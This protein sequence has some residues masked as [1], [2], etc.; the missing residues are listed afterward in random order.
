M[1]RRH[2]CRANKCAGV[3]IAE[4]L[5]GPGIVPTVPVKRH[6]GEPGHGTHTGHTGAHG[7]TDHTDEPHNHPNPTTHPTRTSHDHATAET[8]ADSLG[9][10]KNSR[11]P[12]A[13]R[14][15]RPTQKRPPPANPTLTRPCLHPLP[16]RL[17]APALGAC[18]KA[19]SKAVGEMKARGRS[20]QMRNGR[21][22]GQ[23]GT[24]LTCTAQPGTGTGKK[25][26]G[27]GL[28]LEAPVR[29]AAD[30]SAGRGRRGTTL[31]SLPCRGLAPPPGTRPP[32]KAA[33]TAAGAAAGAR[34]P[35]PDRPTSRL[36]RLRKSPHDPPSA[37]PRR[38]RRR[39]VRGCVC[40]RSVRARRPIRIPLR[41]VER[42]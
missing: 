6:R 42:T 20:R 1:K 24:A 17:P 4:Y 39:P 10:L 8:A 29:A 2:P 5:W 23:T 15:P 38:S 3:H 32:G 40:V 30:R 22:C 7:H 16:E 14:S 35:P 31:H 11:K 33:Q 12:G 9:R 13:D 21:R 26:P 19:C 25:T 36:R 37:I 41:H 28:G 34:E 18:S 27:E